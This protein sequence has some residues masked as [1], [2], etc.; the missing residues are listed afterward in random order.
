VFLINN[1]PSQDHDYKVYNLFACGCLLSISS[2]TQ[3]CRV[4]H[5]VWLRAA[6]LARLHVL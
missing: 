1:I 2:I 6:L 4:V 5:R 3:A